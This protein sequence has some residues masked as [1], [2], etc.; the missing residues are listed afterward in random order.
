MKYRLA[1]AVGVILETWAPRW[2]WARYCVHVL[3]RLIRREVKVTGWGSTSN[4]L[5]D[6]TR[7][8]LEGE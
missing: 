4:D 7:K 5:V 1:W 2:L 3:Y 8:A 6:R